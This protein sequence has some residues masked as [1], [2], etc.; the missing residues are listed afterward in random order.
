MGYDVG[1][2]WM[3]KNVVNGKESEQKFTGPIVAGYGKGHAV[4]VSFVGTNVSVK[5]DDKEYYNADVLDDSLSGKLG[6]RTWGYSGNYASISLSELHYNEVKAPEKDPD[7]NYMTSFTDPDCRGGWSKAW[8]QNASN[9]GLSFVD[10]EGDAG[11]MRAF[12]GP[13]GVAN[14]N[15]FLIDSMS[16]SI[17]N[18]FV[19]F[20]VT[21]QSAG[22]I[23][24]LFRV[25]D[26]TSAN[27][28]YVAI[29][30]KTGTWLSTVATPSP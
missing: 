9:E 23:G 16:P 11:Y 3:V 13:E 17:E 18:G 28:K 14:G 15:A 24:F 5:I 22:R 30:A 19:E 26:L 4:Q 2:V 10:G 29:W 21:N 7:G 1:D 20:D 12:A 25:Q 27:K 6:L 8:S